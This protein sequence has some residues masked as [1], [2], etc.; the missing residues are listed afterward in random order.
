[1]FF[2]ART[3]LI[4]HF[5]IAILFEAIIAYINYYIQDVIQTGY[6]QPLTWLGLPA[7]L[8]DFL[9]TNK[10]PAQSKQRFYKFS[11]SAGN[12]SGT[13]LDSLAS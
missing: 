4:N 9:R 6:I 3:V 10:Q 7:I 11:V 1:M 8:S 13:R 5:F 2:F 12:R